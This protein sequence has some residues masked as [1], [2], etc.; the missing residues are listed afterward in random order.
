MIYDLIVQSNEFKEFQQDAK[1]GILPHAFLVL[2]V[3]LLV[4][5]MYIK[6]L[7]TVLLCKDFGCGKCDDCRAILN[8]KHLAVRTYD[9]LVGAG[10][11]KAA[12]DLIDDVFL[13]SYDYP[14]RVYIIKQGENLSA[15]VQNKLLKTYEEPP[16]DAVIFLL[17]SSDA[18][19]LSTIKSRA[20]KLYLPMFS[21]KQ[22]FDVLIQNGIEK[23]LAEVASTLSGGRFDMAFDLANDEDLYQQYLDVFD[24]LLNLK[25]S[26]DIPKM[27]S[28]DAFFKKDLYGRKTEYISKSLDFIE[29]ILKDVLVLKTGSKIGYMTI[30]KEKELK[31]L[32]EKYSITALALSIEAIGFA[33]EQLNF[34]VTPISV[35]EKLLFSMLENAYLYKD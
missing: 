24:A 35:V 18:N 12:N 13:T 31:I 9:N 19:I 20:T 1:K 7:S 25:T 28:H 3:D 22:I 14:N 30:K 2:G 4:Q 27:L 21:S 16:Q 26:S 5:E 11:V 33:R 15:A 8:N 34:N 10:G 23:D 17:A 29:T 6:A 32:A